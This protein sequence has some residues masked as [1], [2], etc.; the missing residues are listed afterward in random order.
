MN[1]FRRGSVQG[2]ESLGSGVGQS[3]VAP[4]WTRTRA[5]SGSNERRCRRRGGRA[6]PNRVVRHSIAVGGEHTTADCTV[7]SDS[8]ASRVIANAKSVASSRAKMVSSAALVPAP[9]RRAAFN[10]CLLFTF[11]PTLEKR[12]SVHFRE[13]EAL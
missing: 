13:V 5:T 1:G 11:F 9:A 12:Q 2:A 7:S 3:N 10:P 4:S 6:I 8:H